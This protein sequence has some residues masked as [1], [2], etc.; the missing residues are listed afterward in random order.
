MKGKVPP[1][2]TD[3]DILQE[4]GNIFCKGPDRI[5]YFRLSGPGGK[6]NDIM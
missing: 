5:K 6:I 2:K 3:S 4:L 1:H